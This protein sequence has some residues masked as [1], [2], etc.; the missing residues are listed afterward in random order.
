MKSLKVLIVL[1]VL[2]LLFYKT[3]SA[4]GPGVYCQDAS[5]TATACAAGW[6]SKDGDYSCYPAP[7]GKPFF[8]FSQ[9]S[10]TSSIPFS[11]P[12]PSLFSH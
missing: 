12:K 2:S 4:C 11:I 7:A 3:N 9:P 5:E 8:Y 10:H 1:T 6:F